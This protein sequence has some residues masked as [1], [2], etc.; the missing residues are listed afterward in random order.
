MIW[1]MLGI[2]IAFMVLELAAGW[3]AYGFDRARRTDLWLLPTQRF[4][5]RQIMYVVVWRSLM[6]ALGGIGHAWGKLNR[7]GQVRMAADAEGPA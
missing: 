4:I 5:Y 6:R 3:V 7:S 1:L 2:Y